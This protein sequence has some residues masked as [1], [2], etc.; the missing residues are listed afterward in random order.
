VSNPFPAP[1]VLVSSK[2]ITQGA[3]GAHGSAARSQTGRRRV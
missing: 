2:V 1:Q 3:H